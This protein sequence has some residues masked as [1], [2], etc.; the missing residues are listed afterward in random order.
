MARSI[1]TLRIAQRRFARHNQV[2]KTGDLRL[3]NLRRRYQLPQ[4]KAHNALTDALAGAELFL[5]LA[6][7]GGDLEKCRVGDF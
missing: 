3:F 6:A 1:D 7:E 4:Y 5:A 2:L